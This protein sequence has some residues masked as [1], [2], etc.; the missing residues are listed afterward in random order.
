[1]IPGAPRRITRPTSGGK[2]VRWRKGRRVGWTG[3]LFPERLGLH[4]LTE[5]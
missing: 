1:M 5:Q 4:Q 3:Y 2:A